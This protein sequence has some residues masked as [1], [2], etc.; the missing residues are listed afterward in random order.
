MKFSPTWWHNVPRKSESAWRR[1]L[2]VEASEDGGGTMRKGSVYRV[3]FGTIAGRMLTR[4]MSALLDGMGAHDRVISACAATLLICTTL[5]ACYIPAR[6]AAKVDPML[7]L[8][9]E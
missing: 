7:V 2:E 5:V 9:Y 1:V 4:T 8:R 3:C 6:H